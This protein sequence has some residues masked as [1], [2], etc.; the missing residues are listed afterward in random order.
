MDHWNVAWK[1]HFAV[2]R[3]FLLSTNAAVLHW[4]VATV[5][6]HFMPVMLH[7]A[8]HSLYFEVVLLFKL[9]RFRYSLRFV[10]FIIYMGCARRPTPQERC[11]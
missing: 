11:A 9:C 2:T 3:S 4:E 6:I 1:T 8:K 10:V 5:F 7:A